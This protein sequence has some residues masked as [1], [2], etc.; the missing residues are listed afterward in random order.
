MQSHRN[1]TCFAEARLESQANHTSENRKELRQQSGRRRGK[2]SVWL[3]HQQTH[4]KRMMKKLFLITH[5]ISLS[6]GPRRLT[7][8]SVETDIILFF[9]SGGD[10][11]CAKIFAQ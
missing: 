11:G 3:N 4:W 10:K 2:I 8:K 9:K 1:R 7:G 6:R 5:S